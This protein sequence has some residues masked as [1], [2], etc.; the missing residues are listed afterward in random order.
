MRGKLVD[1]PDAARSAMGR[2][3]FV[4]KHRLPEHDLFTDEAL[5]DLLD[6][7]PRELIIA[8]TMGSD[9]GKPGEN[10]RAIHDGVSGAELLRAVKGGRL[11]LNV[12]QVQRCD[13]R[14][15]SLIDSL[16]EDLARQC[17]GFVPESPSGTVLISSPDALVYYHVDGPPSLLW[18]VRGQKRVDSSA[19]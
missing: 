11:W 13:A 1:V 4:G 9:L 10:R 16:Y 8:L 15:R 14:Y 6:H 19:Q 7:H 5:A 17:P 2:T 3:T 18:H 12:V